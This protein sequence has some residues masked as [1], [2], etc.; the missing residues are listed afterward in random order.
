VAGDISSQFLSGL[1]MA[2]PCAAGPVELAVSGDLVSKPYIE[3]TLAVMR[4]FG[5]QVDA[6]DLAR[7]AIPAGRGYRGRSYAV[8]PDASAASYFFAAAA[9]TGGRVTVEGL[10]RESLQGDVAF[11]DCLARMGCRVEYAP[12]AITV[13]G[14]P[15]AGIDVDMNAISDTVQTLGAV[16]LVARGPTTVTGVAHIRHKETDRIAA[17]ATELRKLGAAVEE[18]PDGLRITPGKLHPASID[19]YDDHRMA[20]SM[21]LVGLATPGVVIREPGCTA[22]TYPNYFDDLARLTAS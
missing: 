17:L 7:F 20:M 6:R 14:G 22:K 15:L 10:S 19:T 13:A 12:D 16:A 9:I 2:A 4:S 21:A 3:M 18:R 11:C 5:A 1:L 8:E